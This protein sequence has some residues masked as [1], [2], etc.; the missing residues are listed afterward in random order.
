MEN[1]QQD[2]Y[3]S[4]RLEGLLSPQPAAEPAKRDRS[5]FPWAMAV[6]ALAAILLAL[7]TMI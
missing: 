3:D 7:F 1:N 6:G 4:T 2:I 5:W